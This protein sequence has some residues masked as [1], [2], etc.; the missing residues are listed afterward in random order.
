M[1]KYL[2][3]YRSATSPEDQ[4]ANASPDEAQAGMDAWTEWA[5]RAGSALVDF[6]TPTT[7]VGSV[8]RAGSAAGSAGSAGGFVGGYSIMQAE[9]T[10]ALKRM[11][12][13]HPHLT[14]DD[15]SIEIYELLDVPGQG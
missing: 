5:N 9:S 11:L 2:L 6:G 15:S 12:E 8:G 13:D 4:I 7:A 3:L 10:D 14:T 1:S